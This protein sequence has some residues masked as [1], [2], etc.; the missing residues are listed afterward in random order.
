MGV[1]P[2]SAG[3]DPGPICYGR[4]E[5]ITVT[6]ANL[7][8]GRLIPEHFLGGG[9]RLDVDR[10]D[11]FFSR[12]AKGMALSNIELAEGVISV[13]NTRME[14]AIRMISVERG[15][16]PREF[17]LVSF[18]GAAGMH[19]AYIARL[20][21][22]P[23]VLIPD[24]P[25]ILSALGM[26]MADIIKDY[27]LTVMLS[28]YQTDMEELSRLF[29]SLERK[30]RGDLTAEGVEQE[31]IILERYLDMRYE[32]QSYEILVP[33][34][35]KPI[36]MFHSLHEKRFGYL[37]R[38]KSVEIVNL[39]MRARGVPE[40]PKFVRSPLSSDRPPDD[41]FI[42]QREVIFDNQPVLSKIIKRDGLKSG[43]RLKGPAVIVEYSSTLLVPP[44]ADVFMDGY[45]NLIMEIG[46]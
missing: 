5:R 43:N 3:A 6:D 2:E 17:V 30:G 27:S 24:N 46:E 14:R 1:G 12:M 8:L 19:A 25:G 21:S 13:A 45:R 42:G 15:Y 37:N 35:K 32:G 22:I 44:F 39:R 34:G 41:A 29:R 33:F 10:I 36:E 4:G 7:Y 11:S 38:E 20:L 40:K 16:D 23:K 18:G 28:Q 31:K 26:L 9:M